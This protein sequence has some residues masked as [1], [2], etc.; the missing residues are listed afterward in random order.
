MP[1]GATSAR[2]Q[3][4]RAPARRGKDEDFDIPEVYR[5]MLAEADARDGVPEQPQGDD[6]TRPLKRRRVGERAAAAPNGEAQEDAAPV[7]SEHDS[8]TARQVQTAYDLDASDDVS[9]DESEDMEWE[10]VVIHQ[11]GATSTQIADSDEP[12]QITLD[13]SENKPRAT[14]KRRKPVSGAEKRLRL[15]IHKVHVLCLLQH[16]Y[17]RNLWCNDDETQRFLKKKILNRQMIGFLN[18]RETLTQFNRSTTFIDGLKQ[19]SEAFARQFKVTAPG[20]RRPHWVEDSQAAHER[21]EFIMRDAETLLSK[22]DFRKQAEKLQ[23]SRDF[24]AQLFCAMLRSA[25]VEARL[26]C[27]IQVLPFSGVAKG[28]SP[29]KPKR[30][31]IVISSDDDRNSAQT[32]KSS[33]PRRLAQPLFKSKVTS[34]S[35]ASGKLFCFLAAFQMLTLVD[36]YRTTAELSLL[37]LSSVLGRGIQRSGPEMGPR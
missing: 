34:S 6:T 25:A 22:E 13:Q 11:P 1:R 18:P 15:D 36:F 12:L 10:E 32:D 28:M 27:S 8:S 35:Y 16:V 19:A 7:P 14:T 37:P 9:D 33:K 23:G 30:D 24:G 17:I 20:M 4:W 2:G 31:Y 21:A 3:R 26:V 29:E 5:E